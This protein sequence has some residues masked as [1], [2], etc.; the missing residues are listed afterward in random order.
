MTRRLGVA[1]S[2]LLAT[3]TGGSAQWV[4]HP[5]PRIPRT[6]DGQPD[7]K[8]PAPRLSD[9]R[10][11]LSGIWL[12][13]TKAT[14]GAAPQGQTLGEAPVIL[15]KTEDGTPFPLLPAAQAEYDERLRRG[16]QGPSSRCLPHTIVDY[17][18]VPAA[19]KFVHT[20]GLTILLFEEFQHF[21]QVFTDGR[22]FPEDMQP[23]WFGYSVGRWEGDE[24]V[25]ESAGFNTQGW[26]DLT[27]LRHS[28]SLR[29]TE[30]FRRPQFG[31]LQVQVTITDPTMFSRTWKTQTIWFRLLP[32]TDFVENI[33]ENEKD[34]GLT[35]RQ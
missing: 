34:A 6:A 16:D 35:P 12:P 20:P 10:L 13:D 25:I 32:D 22:R 31:T 1:L 2:L 18:L 26:L 27:P 14:N 15:V 4:N 23:A 30:R 29:T 17:Y 21:R 11:D 7:L 8:A 19:L 9:G 24:F 28:E 5:D 3:A 33:C